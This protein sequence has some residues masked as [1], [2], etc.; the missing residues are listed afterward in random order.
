MRTYLICGGAGYIGSHLCK[1]LSEAGH[2]VVV[3]DDLS[4]GHRELA[5]WGRLEIGSIA[6]REFL[7]R[8]FRRHP[9]DAVVHLGALSIVQDS[10]IDPLAY[11]TANVT[12]TLTLLQVMRQFGVDRL[13]F[14]SSAAVYG[15]P[16][17]DVI[18][19]DHPIQPLSAYGRTKAMVESILQDAFTAYGLRSVSLRYFNAAGADASTLIG[20]AHQPETHL[21]PNVVEA[22]LTG[23]GDV[24]IHGD[25]Y[26]TKDGTCVRDYVHVNDL[27]DAHA[28]ALRYLEQNDGAFA[29]NLGTGV[30]TSVREVVDAISRHVPQSAAKVSIRPRRPG[31]PARLVAGCTRAQSELE[32]F[33]THTDIQEI[34]RS[35]V[36]WHLSPARKK[37]MCSA[38][39]CANM[40]S[41]SGVTLPNSGM[42]GLNCGRAQRMGVR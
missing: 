39:Y 38:T 16:Q 13:V 27:A 8:V 2:Q 10:L 33:P 41:A 40:T 14:S 18:E 21:I 37:L 4:T 30:G 6:D 31:D 26:P 25:D 34:A 20:E 5:I 3:C 24:A 7:E 29:F 32:W 22:F 35:V 15:E 12:G 19:E 1:W 36:R 11:Y 28:R 17:S 23:K 9:I 42:S